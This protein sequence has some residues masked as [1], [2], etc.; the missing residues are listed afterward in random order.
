MLKKLYNEMNIYEVIFMS[1]PVLIALIA[2]LAVHYVLAIATIYLLMKDMGIVKAMIPWNI[3]IL[4]VP[5][6][7]P[8]VYLIYRR[9]AKKK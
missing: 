6:L 9:L 1:L 7:G 2:V 8:T 5:I 3:F 4:L